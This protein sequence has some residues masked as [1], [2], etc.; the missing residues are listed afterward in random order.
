M[1]L[2]RGVKNSVIAEDLRLKGV[3]LPEEEVN[4]DTSEDLILPSFLVVEF[5]DVIF[6]YSNGLSCAGDSFTSVGSS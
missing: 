5:R 1:Q 3:E 6:C 2:A 4:G